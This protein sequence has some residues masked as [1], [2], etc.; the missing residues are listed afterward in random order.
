MS[1]PNAILDLE[2]NTNAVVSFECTMEDA[3]RPP[4]AWDAVSQLNPASDPWFPTD[5]EI[6]WSSY[7]I[8]EPTFDSLLAFPQDSMVF[9]AY[10]PPVNYYPEPQIHYEPIIAA[11]VPDEV[12]LKKL[13][14]LVTDIMHFNNEL[15]TKV[16][17]L[18]RNVEEANEAT[19]A[20]RLDVD[21]TEK[22][23]EQL[24]N[25]I[26]DNIAN[27]PSELQQS[28]QELDMPNS[29]GQETEV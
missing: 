24:R 16:Q 13:E 22:W 2:C 5:V 14:S 18:S 4:K 10:L 3:S 23:C 11:H 28:A 12:G 8:P 27:F 7:D 20:L 25:F 1:E 26:A 15:E 29:G 6:D 21:A 17:Q 9:P 19:Q